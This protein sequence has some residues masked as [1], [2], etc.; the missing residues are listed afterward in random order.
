M[1]YCKCYPHVL[2]VGLK[3]ATNYFSRNSRCPGRHSNQAPLEFER[4]KLIYAAPVDVALLFGVSR[5]SIL[6]NNNKKS[7]NLDRMKKKYYPVR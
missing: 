1:A 4:R 2:L 6:K 7:V 5:T 3:Y